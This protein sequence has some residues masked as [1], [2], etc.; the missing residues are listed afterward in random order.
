MCPCSV[1]GLGLECYRV[2]RRR[3][4]GGRVA[5]LAAQAEGATHAAPLACTDASGRVHF[6]YA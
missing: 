4:E 6:R 1:T 5:W 2:V 3:G